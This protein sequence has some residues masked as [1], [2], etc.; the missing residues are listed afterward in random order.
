MEV[1]RNRKKGKTFSWLSLFIFLRWC[2]HAVFN[3]QQAKL[4]TV[5]ENEWMLFIMLKSCL[6]LFWAPIVELFKSAFNYYS[7]SENLNATW[8]H[9][10]GGKFC[11]FYCADYYDVEE[12]ILHHNIRKEQQTSSKKSIFNEKDSTKCYKSVIS[13]NLRKCGRK[14]EGKIGKE[15]WINNGLIW[16][17]TMMFSASSDLGRWFFHFF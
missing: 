10:K 13:F 11:T 5:N 1:N 6:L 4:S 7:S 14:V 2:F 17:L 16:G 12:V 15:N 9:K 3:K 8:T